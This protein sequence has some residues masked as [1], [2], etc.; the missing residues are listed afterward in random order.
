[1]KLSSATGC[2]WRLLSYIDINSDEKI[3][4]LI[5]TLKAREANILKRLKDIQY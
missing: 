3:M 5:V 1:M 2:P 4:K